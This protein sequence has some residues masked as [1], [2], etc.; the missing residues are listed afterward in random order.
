MHIAKRGGY[1][2][3][4]EVLYVG[5][6]I[7]GRQRIRSEHALYNARFIGYYN[8]VFGYVYFVVR[9]RGDY[10]SLYSAVIQRPFSF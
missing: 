3:A 5:A 4:A 7:C 6:L 9:I 10:G 1:Y 8:A 2:S